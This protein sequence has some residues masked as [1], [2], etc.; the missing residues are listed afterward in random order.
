MGSVPQGIYRI[1]LN[2]SLPETYISEPT[3]VQFIKLPP[4]AL[5]DGGSQRQATA[6]TPIVTMDALT[7]SYDFLSHERFVQIMEP[8]LTLYWLYVFGSY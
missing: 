1:T 3:Y 7:H 6:A 2:V 4:F 8:F 5:I